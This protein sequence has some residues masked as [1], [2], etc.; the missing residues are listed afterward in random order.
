MHYGYQCHKRHFHLALT[1][2]QKG[3]SKTIQSMYI[4]PYITLRL[5]SLLH[6]NICTRA[7]SKKLTLNFDGTGGDNV[8]VHVLCNEKMFHESFQLQ[9]NQRSVIFYP[10]LM[11]TIS[12]YFCLK[13]PIAFGCSQHSGNIMKHHLVNST[14]WNTLRKRDSVKVGKSIYYLI[15]GVSAPR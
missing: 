10:K 6:I 12:Q 1:A 11:L 13:N 9:K 8:I 7:W 4:C 3:E 15:T 14:K 5:C 2:R